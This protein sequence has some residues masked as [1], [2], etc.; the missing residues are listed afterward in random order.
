MTRKRRKFSTEFKAEAVRLVQESSKCLDRIIPLGE[1]HLRR[2]VREYAEHYLFER[3]HQGIGNRIIDPDPRR[4]GGI[5]EVVRSDR[6]GGMLS[7][8]YREAA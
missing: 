5:G 4:L 7:F 8:Y 6:L 1:R 3:H 2:A